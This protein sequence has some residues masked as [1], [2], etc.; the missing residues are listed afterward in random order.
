[1]WVFVCGAEMRPRLTTSQNSSTRAISESLA[2]HFYI[3]C[4]PHSSSTAYI[5]GQPRAFPRIAHSMYLTN[6][7]RPIYNNSPRGGVKLA[8]LIQVKQLYIASW[9]KSLKYKGVKLQVSRVRARCFA[10]SVWS[11]GRIFLLAQLF[12]IL[13]PAACMLAEFQLFYTTVQALFWVKALYIGKCSLK[14][15]INDIF[16]PCDNL[17]VFYPRRLLRGRA[18]FSIIFVYR[19][20]HT[21]HSLCRL[22]AMYSCM[23][24]QT[25]QLTHSLLLPRPAF[26]F[27]EPGPRF[28]CQ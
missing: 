28:R 25:H 6:G 19:F 11:P 20:I 24:T 26:C 12:T 8:V 9:E 27:S 4:A 7:S 21:Q 13:F 14:S 1:M 5:Q 22:T 18:A 23:K 3:C 15:S 10:D 2:S 16:L 17:L